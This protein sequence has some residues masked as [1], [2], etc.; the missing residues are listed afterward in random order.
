[1]VEKFKI[2]NWNIGG[3]KYL[4]EE[5]SKR[6]KIKYDLNFEINDLIRKRNKPDV[7]TLQ[8][9]VRYGKSKNEYEELIDEIEGYR[10]Y[11]FPLI[12]T[13]RLSSKAK[14]NKIKIIEKNGKKIQNWPKDTYFAQGNAFLFKKELTH[15]PVWDLRKSSSNKPTEDR[16]HIEQVNL[17]SG[18]YFGERGSEP[19]APLVAHF[20]KNPKNQDDKPLDIFVIN[21]HLTTLRMEREGIPEIDLAA[22]KIRSW[23]ID[24]IFNGIISRYNRWRRENYEERG[25]KR[26]LKNWETDNRF[27]PVWIIAG[28]FNFIYESVEYERIIKMNFIDLVPSKTIKTKAKGVGNKPTL[29]LD[30]IFG[31]PK[32]I[33]LDKFVYGKKKTDFTQNI[34]DDKVEG[35]DHFPLIASIPIEL[36]PEETEEIPVV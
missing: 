2:A 15:V 16:H 11:S 10:Y 30:Y 35:S 3:A 17:E 8:E 29:T 36:T 25:T 23:Q 21:T 1:M 34:V 7:I 32:F 27:E 6:S 13:D 4:Q 24:V 5:E 18:L 12:D 9:V 31:G 14:W 26:I 19:R 20:L 33:A 28:D 22:R